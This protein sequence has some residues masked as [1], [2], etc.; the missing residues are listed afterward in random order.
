MAHSLTLERAGSTFGCG[1]AGLCA[2]WSCVERDIKVDI[3]L[4]ATNIK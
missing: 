1:G 4:T 3:P 2:I